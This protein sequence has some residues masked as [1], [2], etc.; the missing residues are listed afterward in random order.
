[1]MPAHLFIFRGMAQRIADLA[2]AWDDAQPTSSRDSRSTV[3]DATPGT[4]EEP[5]GTN[6]TPGE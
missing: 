3:L 6:A 4:P 2:E 1:M 5:K